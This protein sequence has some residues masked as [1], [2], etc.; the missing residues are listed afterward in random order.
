MTDCDRVS[1]RPFNIVPL[2]PD[3]A[4]TT[5]CQPADPDDACDAPEYCLTDVGQCDHE[6]NRFQLELTA[7]PCDSLVGDED[8]AWKGACWNQRAGS[9]PSGELLYTADSSKL[10]ATLN[11]SMQCGQRAV[12]PRYQYFFL[13]CA[14]HA[15]ACDEEAPLPCPSLVDLGQADASQHWW[16]VFATTVH[17][18]TLTTDASYTADLDPT[19]VEGRTVHVVVHVFEPEVSNR[20]T[21]GVESVLGARA[22][23]HV[24]LS[25]TRIDSTPPVL[26]LGSDLAA[27]M[28]CASCSSAL[29]EDATLFG[30]LALMG[31]SDN[32]SNGVCINS[33]TATKTPNGS[34]IAGQCCTAVGDC[35]RRTTSSSSDCIAGVLNTDTFV[36]MT[37]VMAQEACSSK[38]LELCEESCHSEGCMY[39]NGFVWTK[40]PCTDTPPSAPPLFTP[41]AYCVTASCGAVLLA[42]GWTVLAEF[43]EMNS[44]RFGGSM[45]R[46]A[47]DLAAAGWERTPPGST[48][49]VNNASYYTASDTLQWFGSPVDAVSSISFALTSGTALELVIAWAAQM[50]GS[51]L[52]PPCELDITDDGGTRTFAAVSD[53]SPISMQLTSVTVSTM[54]GPGLLRFREVGGVC[55]TSYVLA[56][57]V[58]SSAHVFRGRHSVPIAGYAHSTTE[59]SLEMP[60]LADDQS[61]EHFKSIRILRTVPLNDDCSTS[62]AFQR[63]QAMVQGGPALGNL[64]DE[65]NAVTQLSTG[66]ASWSIPPSSA[67]PGQHL[68]WSLGATDPPIGGWLGSPG[69]NPL[70]GLDAQSEQPMPACTSG[71]YNLTLQFNLTQLQAICG[72]FTLSFQTLNAQVTSATLNDH[73]LAITTSGQL[74]LSI[75]P[76]A[77]LEEGTNAVRISVLP[78]GVGIGCGVALQAGCTQ[79]PHSHTTHPKSTPSEPDPSQPYPSAPTPT[80]NPIQS[81]PIPNHPI[82]SNPS[83]SHFTSPHPSHS[84]LFHPVPRHATPRHPAT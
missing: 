77:V 5:V 83:A 17:A 28:S 34:H 64:V 54:G 58:A 81:N 79:Q 39:D 40:L 37:F 47:S 51:S 62:L 68:W 53:L 35:R 15:Y 44:S 32:M 23:Q 25:R 48:F 63:E 33:P 11:V 20:S 2:D 9:N 7:P 70:L 59:L 42:S 18:S 69:W 66:I 21:G 78:L 10:T 30:A 73:D 24:C 71:E 22:Q 67:S 1:L 12:Q 16:D 65:L 26:Q 13:L 76:Q 31:S 80:S 60:A 8:W 75:E 74:L 27:A 56:K 45:I 49:R 19:R 50:G 14:S 29:T 4:S 55:W 6:P 84:I 3:V 61:R 41:T 46:R 57:P 43:G 52:G 38:G 82:P 36:E 72:R